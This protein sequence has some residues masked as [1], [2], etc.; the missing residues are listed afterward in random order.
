MEK[1]EDVKLVLLVSCLIVS[2]A[3]CVFIKMTLRQQEYI[4]R[5]QHAVIER[6]AELRSD[7]WDANYR[8]TQAIVEVKADPRINYL[9][10]TREGLIGRTTASGMI[11]KKDSCF[12][13]L[14]SRSVLGR[15]V[16]VQFGD[17]VRT[18]HV[19]DVGP[20]STED[21]YWRDGSRPM[22]ETNE[23]NIRDYTGNGAGIDLSD[24][25]WDDLGIKRGHGVTLVSW[26]FVE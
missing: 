9:L 17:R 21:P 23:S 7:M 10:A 13:A 3:C 18:V 1:R 12:V 19:E 8:L 5:H 15:R 25:L 6:L 11:I 20:W 2:F 24:A 14:P 22:A 16:E 26:R 4:L